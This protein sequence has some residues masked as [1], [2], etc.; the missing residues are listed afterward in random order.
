MSPE[1]D[2]QPDEQLE[3]EDAADLPEREALSLMDPTRLVG[4]VMPLPGSPTSPPTGATPDPT[5]SSTP[6]ATPTP[7]PPIALPQL[8]NLPHANP[9]GTYQPDVSSTNA[10]KP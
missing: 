2:R 10:S 9:G 6:A 1:D 4:G 5:Q 8:P 3:T 7:M